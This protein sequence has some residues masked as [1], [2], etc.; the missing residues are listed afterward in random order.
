MMLDVDRFEML[1]AFRGGGGSA[2]ACIAKPFS[3]Q[4]LRG[5][6]GLQ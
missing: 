3:E 1:Q 2:V 5:V 6:I 4:D